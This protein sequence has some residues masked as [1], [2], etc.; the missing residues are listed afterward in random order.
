[1]RLAETIGK[2]VKSKVK[3][4]VEDIADDLIKLYAEREA[5]VGHKFSEDGPNRV[6]L[7]VPSL[8]KKRKIKHVPLQR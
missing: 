1:M 2:K 7:K 6:I 5:S 4:S 8:I 3:S